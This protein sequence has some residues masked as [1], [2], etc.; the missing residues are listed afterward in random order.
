MPA[1]GTRRSYAAGCRCVLCRAA[2]AAY[3]A[4]HRTATGSVDAAAVRAHL[5]QLAACGVGY[6][7][8]AAQTGVAASVVSAV[9]AGRVPRLQPATATRLL[10]ARA[11]LAHGALVPGT[12]TWRFVDSLRREGYTHRELAF[13]LGN[14]SQQLQFARRRVRVASAL[15]VASLYERIA[16]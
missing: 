6:R 1:H 8:V 15:R 2:N 3:V 16:S 5:A 13:H 4:G 10:Q 9:R 14:A 11:I 12:R 7:Q